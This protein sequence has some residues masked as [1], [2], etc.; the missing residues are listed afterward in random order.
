MQKTMTIEVL[1]SQIKDMKDQIFRAE[2]CD[3]S[4]ANSG[5]MDEDHKHLRR[6]NDQLAVLQKSAA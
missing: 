4:Y 3:N 5:R 6:L 2:M 1:T